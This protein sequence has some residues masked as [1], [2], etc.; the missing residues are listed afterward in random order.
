MCHWQCHCPGWLFKGCTCG[1][2]VLY[3]QSL[4][5]KSWCL[6][7]LTLNLVLTSESDL[8]YSH[9]FIRMQLLLELEW[10][11]IRIRLKCEF[12]SKKLIST[13]CIP[14]LKQQFFRRLG[15]MTTCLFVEVIKN[16]QPFERIMLRIILRIILTPILTT[17][18]STISYNRG[19]LGWSRFILLQL[20]SKV[21]GQRWLQ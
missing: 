12:L 19:H 3:S 17:F 5:T 15:G 9:R 8:F 16:T 14:W 13:H 7:N 18:S 1:I 10:R 21:R 11:V 2:C 20:E 4:F 6:R